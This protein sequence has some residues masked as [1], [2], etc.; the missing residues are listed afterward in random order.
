[1]KYLI[2]AL[3]R[4]TDPRQAWKVKHNLSE[5]LLIC[6]LAVTAGAISTDVRNSRRTAVNVVSLAMAPTLSTGSA[7]VAA[8]R[9]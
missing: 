8:G 2:K 1:M 4:I 9:C 6:I 5:I 7:A 3:N